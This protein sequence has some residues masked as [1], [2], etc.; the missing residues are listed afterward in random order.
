MKQAL[1]S[2]KIKTKGIEKLWEPTVDLAMGIFLR[3]SPVS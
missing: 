2:G 3:I 1:I